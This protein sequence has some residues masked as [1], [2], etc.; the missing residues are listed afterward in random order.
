[1][2]KIFQNIKAYIIPVKLS[3]YEVGAF[4]LL[5][6]KHGKQEHGINACIKNLY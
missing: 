4:T 2:S 3:E 1:M 6:E 5:I